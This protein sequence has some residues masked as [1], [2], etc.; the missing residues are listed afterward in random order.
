MQILRNFF[1][2][3]AGE[4]GDRFEDEVFV[5]GGGEESTASYGAER[6]VGKRAK[7]RFKG[8]IL[9]RMEGLAVLLLEFAIDGYVG[10]LVETG[11]RFHAGCGFGTTFEDLEI[12]VEEADTPF[13]GFRCI[14]ML[15]SM[16]TALGFF[17]EFAVGYA[18]CRPRFWEMVG[19]ELE[20]FA[21]T[22]IAAR[23]NMFAY[24]AAFFVRIHHSAI[25]INAIDKRNI[26]HAAGVECGNPGCR[27]YFAYYAF[28]TVKYACF[29]MPRH[30]L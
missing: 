1:D 12:M 2:N 27:Y 5:H 4:A 7:D 20:Y 29:E 16:G 15:Q 28:E 23:D 24:A 25:C 30:V 18:G 19:V 6:G 17:D 21:A 10:I 8:N 11:I 14:G 22:G 3:L 26:A 9:V 13:E